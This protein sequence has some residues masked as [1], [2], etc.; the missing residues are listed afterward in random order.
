EDGERYMAYGG[1]FGDTPNDRQFCMNGLVFADRTPHPSLFEAQRAQQFF[2]FSLL[3]TAPLRLQ[4]QSEYLF[5]HSDNEQL[6][7]RIEQDGKVI[8]Q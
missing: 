7:W 1:D 6:V 8:S 3:S 2:Q 4:I 5:R